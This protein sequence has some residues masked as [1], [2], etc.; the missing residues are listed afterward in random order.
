[1]GVDSDQSADRVV[2]PDVVGMIFGIGRALATEAGVTLANPDPDGPPI[3]ALAW[4]GIFIIT[5]QEPEPGTTPYR[6]DS[7]QV[8]VR[9]DEASSSVTRLSTAT[10]P[11]LCARLAPPPDSTFPS[12]VLSLGSSD[13][14][15]QRRR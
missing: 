3:G 8:W 11:S 12:Q 4:P 10:P 6:W 2:V 1:M 15:G 9:A 13:I 5:H 7:V 14:G